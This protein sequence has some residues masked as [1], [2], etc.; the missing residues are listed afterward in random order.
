MISAICSDFGDTHTEGETER[1]REPVITHLIASHAAP[2]EKLLSKVRV[3]QQLFHLITH[4]NIS[5]ASIARLLPFA[6]TLY[7]LISEFF[8]VIS[9]SNFRLPTLAEQSDSGGRRLSLCFFPHEK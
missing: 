4:E 8:Q 6:T 3:C 1:E 2:Y 7:L 9:F 5:F